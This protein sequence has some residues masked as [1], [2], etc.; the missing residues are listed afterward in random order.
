[1]RPSL[2]I[3]IED[4]VAIDNLVVFVFEQGKIK[5]PFEA[6]L[7]HLRKLFRV[8]VAVHADR[9]DLRLFFLLLGE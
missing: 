3:R 7:H 2:A 4:A 8:R 5:L 9:K 1:V 6:A